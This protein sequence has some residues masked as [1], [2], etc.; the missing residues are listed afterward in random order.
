MA[1]L[2]PMLR[3]LWALAS[4]SDSHS[5]SS[6]EFISTDELLSVILVKTETKPNY[7]VKIF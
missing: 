7:V 2:A 5:S 6:R 4:S 3:Q 1:E